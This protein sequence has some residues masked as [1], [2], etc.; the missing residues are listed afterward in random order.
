MSSFDPVILSH[1]AWAGAW[2]WDRLTPPLRSAGLETIAIDLPGNGADG[3]DPALVTFESYLEHLHAATADLPAPFSLVAH[4]GG[5]NVAS[6]YAERWPERVARIVYVAGIML[7]DGKSFVDI[8]DEA[9]KTHPDA[10]GVNPATRYSSDGRVSSVPPEA[11]VKY[12]FND[13]SPAD[14]EAAAR[15]LTPQGEGG[16]A[17]VMRTTPERFG[18]A[19]RLYV[20]ALQDRS[21]IPAVQDL[22]LR[23]SPGARVVSLD[24]GHAPQF[25]AP[26]KLAEAILP[27]LTEKAAACSRGR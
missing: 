27:F 11:A 3:S 10:V 20:K 17:V 25:S 19:P 13:G 9:I 15:R 16:R 14:A 22:M 4:S 2:V 24:T 7:P 1:G 23:L 6:A 18:R 26:A 12:F 5:G 8:V 21:V